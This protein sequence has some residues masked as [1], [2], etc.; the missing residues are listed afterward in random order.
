MARWDEIAPSAGSSSLWGDEAPSR[1]GLHPP[2]DDQRPR[3]LAVRDDE[4][5]SLPVRAGDDRVGLPRRDPGDGVVSHGQPGL[6]ADDAV[7]RD[8]AADQRGDRRRH[9]AG[10]GVRVRDELVGVFAL[11]GQRVRRSA[12]DG[13]PARVLPRV[14]VPRSLAVRLGPA[15]QARSP[16]D[17][18]AGFAGLGA[19]GD[20]HPDGELVDAAPGWL[21]D[22]QERPGGAEQHVGAVR[23][24]DVR[25]GLRARDPRVAGYWLSGHARGVGV[26]S[27]QEGA[28]RVVSSHGEGGADRA[29]P[30]DHD[31]VVRRQ[32]ARR[33]RDPLSA[34]EDRRRRG[35]VEQLQALFVLGGSGRGL[36]QQR[37]DGDRDHP[38]PASAVGAGDRYLERSGHWAE[39]APG[40][41]SEE[42]R[43]RQLH[44]ERGDP[45]LVDADDGGPGL[46]G[47][48]VRVV[49]RV[50]VAQGPIAQLAG[51]S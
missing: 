36:Q 11:C 41:V 51:C 4:H 12:G 28:R 19:L 3:A 39:P 48:A 49:G 46:A 15:S 26:V 37:R 9:G 21:Q 7:L 43:A 20:V 8:V 42:V 33:D 31:P 50:V 6:Q 38:D 5:L 47:A 32:P 29:D 34:G 45:V 30:D 22:R 27:A 14:D 13:G 1:F 40:S 17:D 25:V 23:E 2:G 10:P 24:P 18:L 35:A 16:G 44:P